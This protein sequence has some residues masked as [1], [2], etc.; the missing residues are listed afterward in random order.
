MLKEGSE[1]QGKREMPFRDEVTIIS[2][3]KSNLI[4]VSQSLH[5]CPLLLFQFS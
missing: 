4:R 2:I 1:V 3:M 5:H